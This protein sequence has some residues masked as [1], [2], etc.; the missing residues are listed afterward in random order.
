MSDAAEDCGPMCLGTGE[1]REGPLEEVTFDL[2]SRK[3]KC[4]KPVP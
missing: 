4:K 3:H 2:R 1:G